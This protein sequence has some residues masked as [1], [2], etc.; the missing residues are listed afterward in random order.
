MSTCYYKGYNLNLSYL[1]RPEGL[2]LLQTGNFSLEQIK[3]AT[4]NF[5]PANKIGEGRFGPVYKVHLNSLFYLLYIKTREDA[6][7]NVVFVAAGCV[8]R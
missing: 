6:R 3:A 7:D 2:K 1:Q 5:D 4:N 8:I